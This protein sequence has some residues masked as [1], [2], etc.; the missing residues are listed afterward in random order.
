MFHAPQSGCLFTSFRFCFSLALK[1][2]LEAY[3]RIHSIL[4]RSQQQ[5]APVQY[6]FTFT[7]ERLF[8]SCTRYRDIVESQGGRHRFREWGPELNL[9][10]STEELLCPERAFTYADLYAM[11][12]NRNNTIAWLTPHVAVAGEI[13]CGPLGAFDC[14]FRLNADGKRMEV[15]ARSLEHSLEICDVVL[16]LLAASVVDWKQF[17][18]ELEIAHFGQ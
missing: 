3:S 7:M 11:L 15:T 18:E 14:A 16:R 5:A 8:S 4:S 12:G 1:I 10:V 6:Y 2:N 17:S 9:D 13:F